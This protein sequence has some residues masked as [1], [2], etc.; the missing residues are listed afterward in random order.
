MPYY[1]KKAFIKAEYQ[2]ASYANKAFN[3][4]L[5]DIHRFCN[6]CVYRR[7]NDCSGYNVGEQRV[8][9]MPACELL[10]IFH[11]YDFRFFIKKGVL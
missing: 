3:R 4:V 5:K 9:K 2:I 6:E 8:R 1:K 11:T 10:G 7:G